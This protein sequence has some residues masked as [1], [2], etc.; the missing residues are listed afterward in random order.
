MKY[1]KVCLNCGGHY[2]NEGE[3][4]AD[5]FYMNRCKFEELSDIEKIEVYKNALK[6][7]AETTIAAIMDK[8]IRNLDE[9]HSYFERLGVIIRE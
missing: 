4:T 1:K 7:S 9:Q 3:F 2:F 5:D 6:W 8:P